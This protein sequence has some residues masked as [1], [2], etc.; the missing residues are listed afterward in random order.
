MDI[1]DVKKLLDR[2]ADEISDNIKLYARELVE[3]PEMG[4]KEYKTAAYVK[5]KLE[6]FG[7]EVESGLAVTGLKAT[8]RGRRHEANICI[9]GELDAV[10]CPAHPQS[11][12]NSGA[13]H[14]CGHNI[15]LANLLGCAEALVRSG[16]AAY[17]DGDITFMATPAEE[18]VE[19]EYRAALRD[20]GKISALS[21]KQE[22]L[23]LGAFDGIDCA[24]MV[25]S[26]ADCPERKL[27]LGG[28]GLGFVAKVITFK[29]KEAHAGGA[30]FDG[31]NALNAAMA[32]I[33][34]IHAMRE[35]FRDEDKIRVHPIITKG[36][37]LV[38][39]VPANVVMETYVRGATE[40]AVS[41]ACFKVDRAIKG[42]AYALGC[43]VEICDVG[44]YAP[45]HQS[46]EI[47]RLLAE[48]AIGLVA[49]EDITYGVDMV[50]STDVGDLCAVIPA[51]QPTIGGFAGSAHSREFASVD[52][53]FTDVV[54]VKLMLRCVS[55]LL[56]DGAALARRIKTEFD[57][58]K[59]R[60]EN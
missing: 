33:M 49:S 15:Q 35:T 23:K 53:D 47:T 14:A 46:D 8:L 38:N 57:M 7:F 22:L 29:G 21:G 24:M 52:A 41:D 31:I 5:Q 60:E 20:A 55:E 19:L 3:M 39:I 40:K 54:P 12:A 18:F 27:F 26:Q 56:A 59:H 42:A 36:G 44:G 16:A 37:D 58:S 34:C 48:N 17:L 1:T 51:V 10:T 45:L 28:S 6:S 32:A 25:H 9:M 43:E 4:F 2:T 30:P 11:D 50:G 13:A